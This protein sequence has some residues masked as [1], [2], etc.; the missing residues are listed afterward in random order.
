MKPGARILDLPWKP[1]GLVL[2]PFA[3][4][5]QWWRGVDARVVFVDRHYNE[6]GTVQAS[7]F[8]LPFADATFDQAWADP[9]HFIRKSPLKTSRFGADNKR[10]VDRHGNKSGDGRCY[11]GA[12]PDRETL[13]YEWLLVAME[14]HR[15]VKP[16]GQLVWKSITGAKTAS[17]CVNDADLM[18]CLTPWWEIADYV[19]T[20]S[21]VTWSSAQTVHTL[22]RRKVAA[23][24]T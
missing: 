14:L 16:G 21:R 15:V 6:P 23:K 17:Q 10:V 12:Y 1:D 13:R 7:A 22:W 4:K 19:S 3:G 9:P 5:R 20:R 2:D 18:F 8:Q 11:F 24:A